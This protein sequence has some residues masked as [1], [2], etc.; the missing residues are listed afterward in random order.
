MNL[1]RITEV[2]SQAERLELQPVWVPG[3]AECLSRIMEDPP[4]VVGLL[5]EFAK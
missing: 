4:R 1:A 3:R 2:V 5:Q